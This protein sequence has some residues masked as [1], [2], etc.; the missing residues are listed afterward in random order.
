MKFRFLYLLLCAGSLGAKNGPLVSS[1]NELSA[2]LSGLSVRFVLTYQPKSVLEAIE[3]GRTRGFGLRKSEP[4]MRKSEEDVRKEKVDAA[5]KELDEHLASDAKFAFLKFDKS[6][7][8]IH[9]EGYLE[10]L[11]AQLAALLDIKERDNLLNAIQALQKNIEQEQKKLEEKQKNPYGPARADQ[12][13]NTEFA[14]AIPPFAQSLKVPVEFTKEEDLSFLSSSE[15]KNIKENLGKI[16]AGLVSTRKNLDEIVLDKDSFGK[17]GRL[18]AQYKS[19]VKQYRDLLKSVEKDLQDKNALNAFLNL[20][21]TAVGKNQA[22]SNKI[23]QLYLMLDPLIKLNTQIKDLLIKLNEKYAYLVTKKADIE[24]AFYKDHLDD[25]IKTYAVSDYTADQE[26]FSNDTIQLLRGRLKNSAQMVAQFQAIKGLRNAHL[27]ELKKGLLIYEHNPYAAEFDKMIE[28]FKKARHDS[29]VSSFERDELL[30]R[31]IIA[32]NQEVTTQKVLREK[33]QKAKEAYVKA[34]DGSTVEKA[35][36]LLMRDSI[37]QAVK[38]IFDG[39]DAD[40]RSRIYSM[41][42]TS[43]SMEDILKEAFSARQS[44]EPEP[45]KS[46]EEEEDAE[47]ASTS[48]EDGF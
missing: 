44:D 17:L 1:L 5:V 11:N 18:Y 47:W 46:L 23:V 20:L 13:K 24:Q 34:I 45:K 10:R 42:A 38:R 28:A 22:K 16:L 36:K 14:K 6:Q 31:A 37:E 26:A 35:L 9:M 29:S 2:V 39:Y 41:Y 7:V 43:K 3:L 8:D 4:E 21:K 19:V 25:V 12:E 40:K 15:L 48:S 33:I 32:Y 27:K 30:E